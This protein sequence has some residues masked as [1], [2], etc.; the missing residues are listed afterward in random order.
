MASIDWL[1]IY[2]VNAQKLDFFSVLHSA[3]S[4]HCDGGINSHK[5]SENI[6]GKDKDKFI[7]VKYCDQFAHVT[8]SD[9]TIRHVYVTPELHRYK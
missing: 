1:K 3:A 6:N 8:W 2:G 7:D 5:L 9:G 4:Q